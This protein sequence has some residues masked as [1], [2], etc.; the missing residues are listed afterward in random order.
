[1]VMIS[2]QD[3]GGLTGDVLGATNE[4]ARTVSLLLVLVF[5]K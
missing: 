5:L 1:M 3:F 4:I 2:N